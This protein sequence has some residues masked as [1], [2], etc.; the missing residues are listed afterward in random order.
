MQYQKPNPEIKTEGK[1]SGAK[2]KPVC[3]YCKKIVHTTN[4]FILNKKNRASKSVTVLKA[5]VPAVES[6]MPPESVAGK[7]DSVFVPFIMDGFVSLTQDGHEVPIVI[8]RDSAT[9]QSLILEGVL[10]FS[11]KSSMQSDILVLGV[12]WQYV[13]VPLHTVYLD[14][15]LVSG[16]VVVGVRDIFP[17]FIVGNDLVGGKVLINPQVT[18]VPLTERPDRLRRKFPGMFPVPAIT[19]T[20][21]KKG[22]MG[23]VGT[24]WVH[25][26]RLF[27]N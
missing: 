18:A 3:F 8:L 21:S 13:G 1:D 23:G 5:E 26:G 27:P 15:K 17:A 25:V 6:L 4:C 24:G 12:V 22:G 11:N 20:M 10:S 9:S 19:R 16:P 14:S 2:E 7:P